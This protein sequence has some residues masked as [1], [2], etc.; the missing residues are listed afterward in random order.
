MCVSDLND[1]RRLNLCIESQNGQSRERRACG[2]LVVGGEHQVAAQQ[3]E[4]FELCVKLCD[5]NESERPGKRKRLRSVGWFG[6][7]SD[8]Y[9]ENQTTTGVF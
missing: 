8:V 4:S 2:Y 3:S 5:E 9:W 1:R 6:G 7:G